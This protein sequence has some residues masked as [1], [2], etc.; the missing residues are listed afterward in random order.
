MEQDF[1]EEM[2]AEQTQRNPNFPRMVDE[3]LGRLE[4]A[5][6]LIVARKAAKLSQAVIAAGMGAPRSIVAGLESGDVQATTEILNRY[7]AALEQA[8]ALRATS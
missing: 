4:R 2:I 5:D 7:A 1:L 6:E 8:K 3:E